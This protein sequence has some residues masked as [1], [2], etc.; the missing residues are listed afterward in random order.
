M[1]LCLSLSVVFDCIYHHS[2]VLFIC[3]DFLL[4]WSFFSAALLCLA[5]VNA[6]ADVARARR[7]ILWSCVDVTDGGMASL[8]QTHITVSY[9]T[10]TNV[11]AW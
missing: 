10:Q 4:L 7:S 9:Y 1:S 2:I 8:Q 3:V 6:P 11:G 5:I